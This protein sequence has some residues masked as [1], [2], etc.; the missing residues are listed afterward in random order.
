MAPYYPRLA[1]IHAH[2]L[3]VATPPG[4]FASIAVTRAP[5]LRR[6]P[7]D[8][9]PMMPAPTIKMCG[10]SLEIYPFPRRG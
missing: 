2:E 3:S 9:S 10:G 8:E 4:S 7:R 6:M 1:L 5:D